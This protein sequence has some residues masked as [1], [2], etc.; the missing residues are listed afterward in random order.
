MSS[1]PSALGLSFIAALWGPIA[2]AQT[3]PTPAAP[4][5]AALTELSWRSALAD[6]QPFRDEKVQPWRASN[7][8]VGAV[9]GWRA[10]AKEAR[11]PAST[12]EAVP[13]P[14]PHAGHRKP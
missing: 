14:D 7:D 9:G 6:Y 13:A 11:Q 4:P 1:L 2:A 12:G 8:T 5:A 3:P 10:Y